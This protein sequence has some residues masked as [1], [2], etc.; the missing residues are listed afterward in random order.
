MCGRCSPGPQK[1]QLRPSS[2]S[3]N[4]FRMK[5][6]SRAEQ[7]PQAWARGASARW[8]RHV[9]WPLACFPQLGQHRD[10]GKG[11]GEKLPKG[12]RD[13]I[14]FGGAGVESF[15]SEVEGERLRLWRRQ[16]PKTPHHFH[17]TALISSSLVSH[18]ILCAFI[19]RPGSGHLVVGLAL[20]RSLGWS[21]RS[22]VLLRSLQGLHCGMQESDE[23][24]AWR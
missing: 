14:A 13:H 22:R 20:G 15:C 23:E 18:T 21:N 8:H 10:V 7:G 19:G 3:M 1:R 4:I 11:R 24:R 9:E 17:S 6:R 2:T 5:G 16:A 12:K